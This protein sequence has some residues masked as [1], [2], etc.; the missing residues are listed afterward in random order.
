MFFA[1]VEVIPMLQIVVQIDL[2]CRPETGLM[3]FVHLP[4]AGIVD[5]EDHKPVLVLPQ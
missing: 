5:R 1:A 3:F 2:F 4:D